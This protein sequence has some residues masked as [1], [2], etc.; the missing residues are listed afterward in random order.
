MFLLI[1]FV[2]VTPSFSIWSR[3]MI[4]FTKD[5][6]KLLSAN[7]TKCSNTLKQFVGFSVLGIFGSL[8]LE[9]IRVYSIW[10][11]ASA[12]SSFKKLLYKSHVN[13]LKLFLCL[14][15]VK[16]LLKKNFTKNDFDVWKLSKNVF[17]PVFF[18]RVAILRTHIPISDLKKQVCMWVNLVIP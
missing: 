14:V 6:L 18:R 4:R 13:L 5:S 11:Y 10:V 12:I 7:P 17:F 9:G 16:N 15:L 1:P 2:Q 8:V 3:Y